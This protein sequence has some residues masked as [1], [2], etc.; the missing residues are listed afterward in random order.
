MGLGEKIYRYRTGK[1]LSQGELAELLEVSRQSVSKWETDASVPELDKLVR[2]SRIFGVSLD[3]LILDRQPAEQP[4]PESRVISV[5][6]TEKAPARKIIGTV[7]L[8]FAALV[9][10]LISLLG[11]ILA[12]LMWAA[13]FAACAL[14]CLLV[15]KH[16]GLWCGW[17]SY[18]F[19]DIYLRCATGINRS[20]ILSAQ[21]YTSAMT[22]Q[23]ILAWCMV[24]AFLGL[25]VITVLCMKKAHPRS[26]SAASVGAA[27][28]WGIYL[29]TGLLYQ[30][31]RLAALPPMSDRSDVLAFSFW[32]SVFG[33]LRDILLIAALVLTA[34]L[35]TA[36][37][38]KYRTR[39]SQK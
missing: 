39:S 21:A 4:A 38:G 12:G 35:L 36:L 31:V 19:A 26:L 33:W 9:W 11:D 17:V 2:L 1:N 32:S 30:R 18:L 16:S 3:E 13:P 37:W 6:Q 14:V 20:Y 7:L 28:F 15:K 34:R 8:C 29:L 25:T 10:L 23:L 24:F 27:A 5:Q 22:V